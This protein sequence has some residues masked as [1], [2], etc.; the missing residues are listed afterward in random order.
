MNQL[1][2]FNPQSGRH[3]NQFLFS[4][5]YLDE[6]L[7]RT[8]AW[9]RAKIPALQFGQWLLAHYQQEKKQLAD[10]SEAQLEVHWFEPIFKQLGWDGAYETQ[11]I[12][13]A[14]T[15]ANIRKPDF[16]FFPSA[17]A[18]QTA[19]ALQ[20]SPAYTRQAV[21]V[22]EVKKW[23]IPLNKKSQGG[24][25]SFDNSNP[26]FQLDTYL[27]S[28]N[29]KWG[30][31]SNGRLW[32][33]VNRENSSRLVEYFEIDLIHALE[34]NQQN[35]LLYFYL[36]F[37]HPS[38]TPN[39]QGQIF[40]QTALEASLQYAREL[41]E[42]LRENAY[43]A[44]EQLINGFFAPAQN[45][46]NPQNPADLEAVYNNSLY[47]LY[48]LLFLFYGESRGLFPLN[49]KKYYNLSL[50]HLV[51]YV[52]DGNDVLELPP[53]TTLISYY[54]KNLFQVINGNNVALN[55][56]VKVPRYNGGLFNP[57]IHQFLEKHDVGD[58][59]LIR[60]IDYL[61][62]RDQHKQGDY[63]VKE[64][65][66]YRTLGI[67]QLGSIY[68]GLLEY[69]VKN[70]AE[71]MVT[72]RQDGR[73]KWLPAAKQGRALALERREVGELYLAT[74]NEERRATGSYYTP[75]YI[76]KYIVSQTLEPLIAEAKEQVKHFPP[77]EQPAHFAEAILSLKIVDPAMGSGH[78]LVEATHY[79]AH[80]LANYPGLND[81]LLFWQRQVVER[82]IYGVDK[83]L[84]AVELAK[85]SLWLA[86]VAADKPLSFLDHHLQHGDA[87]IGA[88]IADLVNLPA[89]Q[90]NVPADQ[91]LLFAESAFTQDMFKVVGGIDAIQKL[92]SETVED[93]HTKEEIYKQ[94]RHHLARWETLAHIW[95]SSFFGLEI[96]SAE[97][98]ELVR[99]MQGKST[100]LRPEQLQPFLDHPVVQQNDFFHWELRFPEL[101]FDPNGQFLGEAAGFDAVI[102]NPP[103]I[104]HEKITAYKPFLT[105]YQTYKESADIYV[106]FLEKGLFSLKYGRH[107]GV[108]VSNKFVRADYG[109]KLR[110]F[111]IE[112]SH[113]L[114]FIDFGELPVFPEAST[115]P[116]I[117]I[118]QRNGTTK[119]VET[120]I[121]NIK[122]LQFDNLQEVIEQTAFLIN[123]GNLHPSGWVFGNTAHFE[124]MSRLRQQFI[125]LENYL[126]GSILSGIKTGF[127]EAFYIDAQ[128]KIKFQKDK[129]QHLLLKPLLVGDDI[130]YYHIK[131]HKASYMI[132]TPHGWTKKSSGFTDETSAWAWFKKQNPQLAHHLEKFEENA[133]KRSDQGE[134]W[135][136][137]RPCDYYSA[138][139]NPK[140]IYPDIAISPRFYMD[141]QN[142]YVD[143]TAF[144]IPQEDYYL[145]ALL[146]SKLLF[147]FM[148][149][150]AAV[151]GDVEER[152]RLR[153]K[154]IYLKNLPIPAVK[155]LPLSQEWQT[156]FQQII[157]NTFA[158]DDLKQNFSTS[159]LNQFTPTLLS[160]L[161]Q[162]ML[163][164]HQEQQKQMQHFWENLDGVTDKTLFTKLQKGKWQE[165]L[166]KEIEATRPFLSS[167]TGRQT[168]TLDQT[169]GWNEETFKE[170]VKLLA[171]KVKNM[172]DLLEIYRQHHPAY[173][174]LA[175]K[176]NQTDTLI[177]QLVYQ[178][179]GLTEAEIALLEQ[180]L[181]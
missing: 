43:K 31:L 109:R 171:G 58:A 155:Q 107:L 149:N 165:T 168:I 131:P 36:F 2:L 115:F 38:F 62:R 176:I 91:P 84:L 108:I 111:L 59:F 137:L 178:L 177:N 3:N 71:P 19:V 97:Y 126:T 151:L 93:I 113:V 152:G 87:L 11:A 146:N 166:Y 67:R 9:E 156:K 127:N 8:E 10:Y 68:E 114:Q 92:L 134:F 70:A 61:A 81:E 136:E 143:M 106:C 79:L 17:A 118:L 120:L 86:T 112:K 179:Y 26:M 39:Q 142:Y 170:M 125:T 72:I 53:M 145:L 99:F 83:N 160:W 64:K 163:T 130:R 174:A 128:T 46:L 28:T 164:L 141:K 12:I 60:A 101:F 161:A 90:K 78:F 175:E 33:L 173:F 82:C 48:R 88:K 1:S 150:T 76:V 15:S 138:F 94:L 52:I 122:N 7:P 22:G 20:N 34:Q 105:R 51:D 49:H 65:V 144:V 55:Q 42:D 13:P 23:D 75:D 98:Q 158:L 181:P 56:E 180:L 14:L 169:L 69:Q 29:L 74:D 35:T 117:L 159:E 153:F 63:A 95:V 133:R 100:A 57:E 50:T 123:S 132:T 102:G 121:A 77:A 154:K 110:E 172:G 18:R 5:Y 89:T 41:E 162:Q 116:A 119:E 6:L 148:Q 85:V 124:L 47:L 37:A 27:R 54:L 4:D 104:R 73:E 80:V 167:P 25:S 140:I 21:A 139:E 16:V 40:V 30:I 66:D 96:T 135:W 24:Q 147:F 32:R 44:L 103:Y 45:Q 157:A 129:H